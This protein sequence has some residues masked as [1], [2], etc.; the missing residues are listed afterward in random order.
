M[1][2]NCLDYKPNINK[3]L[4]L[5]VNINGKEIINIKLNL[6]YSLHLNLKYIITKICFNVVTSIL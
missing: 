2:L 6:N 4:K 5:Q 3:L 1:P